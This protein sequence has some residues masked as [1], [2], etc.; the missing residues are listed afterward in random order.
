M[1]NDTQFQPL[2]KSN[3]CIYTSLALSSS[4]FLGVPIVPLDL[5][6]T[7]SSVSSAMVLPVW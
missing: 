5:K 3:D 2:A 4:G 7:L 6:L 1:L